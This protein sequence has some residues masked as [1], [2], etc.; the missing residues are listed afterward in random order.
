MPLVPSVLNFIAGDP[1]EPST[2][3]SAPTTENFQD[4]TPERAAEIPA[5]IGERHKLQSPE[6]G[7]AL[8]ASGIGLSHDVPLVFCPSQI[9]GKLS[10]GLRQKVGVI[11]ARANCRASEF[12]TGFSHLG[13]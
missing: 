2:I 3:L 6:T 11:P 8:G 4:L 12:P 13:S 9:M 1:T 7:S 10:L 5:L